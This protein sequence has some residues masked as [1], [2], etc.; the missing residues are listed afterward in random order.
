MGSRS[1]QKWRRSRQFLRVQ[2]KLIRLKVFFKLFC[3]FVGGYAF[4]YSTEPG[5][6]SFAFTTNIEEFTVT[7]NDKGFWEATK[8]IDFGDVRTCLGQQADK[9]CTSIHIATCVDRNVYCSVLPYP[10]N[11][12][13][14]DH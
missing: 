5:A 13:R 2:F 1:E 10:S 6:A 9:S 7:C 4:D 3:C 11:S 12:S 14:S 8:M